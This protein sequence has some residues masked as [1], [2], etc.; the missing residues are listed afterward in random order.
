MV[1]ER[2]RFSDKCTA[3]IGCRI[4]RSWDKR[5]IGRIRNSEGFGFKNILLNLQPTEKKANQILC[6][7]ANHEI[8]HGIMTAKSYIVE[9]LQQLN[10]DEDLFSAS[11][12]CLG[13]NHSRT[14]ISVRLYFRNKNHVFLSYFTV[15][16]IMIHELTH[17]DCAEHDE[18]FL[19]RE[20]ELREM[21]NQRT[22]LYRVNWPLSNAS[23]HLDVVATASGLK[24]YAPGILLLFLLL[25]F[26]ILIVL[27]QQS[28]Y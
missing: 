2:Y 12:I 22:R 28:Y 9:N 24:N 6:Q 4:H 5:F 19:N 15:I 20:A 17:M 16:A 8:L 18:A 3:S 13:L 26:L 7:L 25:T 27:V 21:Y 11:R 10:N 1:D 14:T 23:V